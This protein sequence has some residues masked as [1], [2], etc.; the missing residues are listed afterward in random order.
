VP[1]LLIQEVPLYRLLIVYLNLRLQS[2]AL[3]QIGNAFGT[4]G[5]GQ[6]LSFLIELLVFNVSSG[7]VRRLLGHRSP[8][9]CGMRADS[10]VF[11]GHLQL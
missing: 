3:A 2:T 5:Q 6:A 7:H 8:P 1:A 11:Q 10:C 4:H 9:I